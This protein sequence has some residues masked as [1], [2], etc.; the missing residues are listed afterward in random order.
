MALFVRKAISKR[1]EQMQEKGPQA[2]SR[3]SRLKKGNLPT[4]VYRN[5]KDICMFEVKNNQDYS[6]FT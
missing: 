5:L 2:I 3:L 1:L 6:V 4:L